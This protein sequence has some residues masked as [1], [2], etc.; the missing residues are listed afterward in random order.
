VVSLFGTVQPDDLGIALTPSLSAAGALAR[1]E[2]LTG[3]RPFGDRAP[4]LVVLPLED[5]RY[6]LT[7]VVRATTADGGLVSLFVDARTGEEVRRISEIQTQAAVG[8]GTGVLGERKKLAVRR[9]SGVFLADDLLRPGRLITYDMRGNL[10][11]TNALLGIVAV[12]GRV[13][14]EADMAADTDNSWTDGAVVDAHA[15]MGVT[16]DYYFDR[17][18]RRGY[19]GTNTR[20]L[21]T[22]VHPTGRDERA[23]RAR[24][25][26]VV[27]AF[28]CQFCGPNEEGI[29]VFGDGLDRP[30]T[31]GGQ[32]VNYFSAG[33]DIVAHEYSHAVTRFSANLQ[34][35]GE[36]GALNESFS[37]IMAIGV[38]FYAAA[39]G[40]TRRPGS[41]LLG[42]DVFTAA[43]PYVRDGTRSASNPGQFGQ[44]D[45][46][47]FRYTGSADDGGV[48]I[49]SGISNRAFYLAIEGGVGG[50]GAAP[51]VVEGVGAENRAQIERIFYR[52]FMTYLTSNARFAQAR[53]ATVQAAAD[54][55]GPS[56]PA[57]RAVRAAWTAV[58]VE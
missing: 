36:S 18:N 6:R 19:D 20:P 28:F 12:T 16:Y 43:E 24:P 32:Y 3:G 41:Y 26:L 17:F 47:A 50:Y 40:R 39:T 42:E 33:L 31:F 37:D 49:N 55:Y 5:G 27:N 4:E 46:Y 45:D 25:T 8:A 51:V 52:G 34:Y 53:Q 30:Q 9:A 10:D 54:L 11:R 2:V 35:Y 48:H 29:L 21:R 58:G 44:P 1:V 23:L 38:E 13:P 22:F 7:W 57:F 15:G 14:T 56:S